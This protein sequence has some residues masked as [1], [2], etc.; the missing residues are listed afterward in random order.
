MVPKNTQF[1]FGVFWEHFLYIWVTFVAWCASKKASMN[2]ESG[3][4][5]ICKVKTGKTCTF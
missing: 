5:F 1:A 3:V 4:L 2:Y